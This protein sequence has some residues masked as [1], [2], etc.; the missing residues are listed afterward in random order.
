MFKYNELSDLNDGTLVTPLRIDQTSGKIIC[1][2]SS[3]KEVLYS[4]SDF[5]FS[6]TVSERTVTIDDIA[7]EMEKDSV[8]QVTIAFASNGIKTE[9]VIKSPTLKTK[10]SFSYISEYSLKKKALLKKFGYDYDD[11][12]KVNIEEAFIM[13]L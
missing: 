10:D 8:E 11:I 2:D 12:N 13:Y 1:L 5:N 4:F 6:K 7:K 9:F 3:G